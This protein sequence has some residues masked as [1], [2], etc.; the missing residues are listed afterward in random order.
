MI[1]LKV[2]LTH[3]LAKYRKAEVEVEKYK[4]LGEQYKEILGPRTSSPTSI[5]IHNA[6]QMEFAIQAKNEVLTKITE[7]ETSIKNLDPFYRSVIT[8]TKYPRV[9]RSN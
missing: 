8:T 7:L 6:K 1:D 5:D 3:E 4:D 9:G 2:E